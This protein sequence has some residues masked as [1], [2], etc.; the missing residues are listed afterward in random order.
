M[1]SSLARSKCFVR[2]SAIRLTQQLHVII[3]YYETLTTSNNKNKNNN[4]LVVAMADARSPK[5]QRES[6]V[7]KA[8]MMCEALVIWRRDPHAAAAAS[9]EET[10]FRAFFGCGPD[11]AMIAWDMLASLDM[12][13]DGGLITHFL[14]GLMFMKVYPGTKVMQ[15]L[16]GNA[17]NETMM[18]WT[19]R[20]VHAIAYL[21]PHV[22]SGVRLFAGACSHI[23]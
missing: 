4:Y 21:E 7:T 8:D 14:W 15:V 20:F 18:K 16:C 5:R 12:T 22:V 11:V 9:S 2:T 10:T 23:S 1:C 19:M 3:L 13:P 6:P 17:D